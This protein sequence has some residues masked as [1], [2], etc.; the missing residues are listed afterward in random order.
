M[1]TTT[2][3][4]PSVLTPRL[5]ADL[6]DPALSMPEVAER[7][8]IP[9]LDLPALVA[10]DTFRAQAAALAEAES[11]RE[12]A[13]APLRRSRALHT[14]TIL[15]AQEPTSATQ[16]ESARRAATT[17]LKETTPQGHA[18]DASSNR[19]VPVPSD[20]LSV[21]PAMQ[22]RD[23]SSLPSRPAFPQTDSVDMSDPDTP[24]EALEELRT[25]LAAIAS[26]LDPNA[27]PHPTPPTPV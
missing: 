20:P 27:T 1:H 18:H 19:G 24:T 16:A 7:H 8:Q 14:L 11:I 25:L 21:T 17:L 4:Q 5:I 22:S 9:L 10:S 12:T 26:G 15:T 2:Q 3:P 23:S 6:L 13:L